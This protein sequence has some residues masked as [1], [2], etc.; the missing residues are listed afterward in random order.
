MP[1]VLQQTDQRKWFFAGSGR[2]N[3]WVPRAADA[4]HFPTREA[5]DAERCPDN[6]RVVAV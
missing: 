2:K 6:E 1:Y 4:H 3:T 5:A